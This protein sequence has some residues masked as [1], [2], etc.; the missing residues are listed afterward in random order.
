[1]RGNPGRC[2]SNT[3]SKEHKGPRQK[4][5]SISS[6]SGSLGSELGTARRDF[7]VGLRPERWIGQ[8]ARL[9]AP[10]WEGGFVVFYLMPAVLAGVL[11]LA[12]GTFL[13]DHN[14]SYQD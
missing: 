2:E 6:R 13:A 3:S 8:Q 4:A 1:M 10:V 9:S 7:V 12:Q 11:L 5:G 14:R